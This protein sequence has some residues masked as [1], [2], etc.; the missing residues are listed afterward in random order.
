[1]DERKKVKLEPSTELQQFLASAKKEYETFPS[2][3]QGNLNA[4]SQYWSHSE[5]SS[6]KPAQS[7]K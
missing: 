3:K 7:E 5:G 4:S 2:W 1:M 6:Q